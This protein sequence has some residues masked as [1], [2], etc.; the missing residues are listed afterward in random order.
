MSGPAWSGLA[1][2][3]QRW[4]FEARRF[5][6][7]NRYTKNQS[8]PYQYTLKV[9]LTIVRASQWV[10]LC[11]PRLLASQKTPTLR[12]HC[13]IKTMR[14]VATKAHLQIQSSSQNTWQLQLHIY[15]HTN[16]VAQSLQIKMHPW[17]HRYPQSWQEIQRL[18]VSV[19]IN[20]LRWQESCLSRAS[21]KT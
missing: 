13:R 7:K 15:A 6:P 4:L 19:A 16:A 21:Q 17:V 14:P 8:V 1:Q 5:L 11:K 2:P 20:Q 3:R 18:W 12:A 9:H 10:N